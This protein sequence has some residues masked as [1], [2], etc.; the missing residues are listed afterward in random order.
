MTIETKYNIGDTVYTLYYKE[1]AKCTVKAFN[2]E[3]N[4]RKDIKLQYD[5]KAISRDVMLSGYE[6]EFI[7]PSKEEAAKDWLVN[8]GLDI[9]IK[10][11]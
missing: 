6:E 11:K 8:Q 9:D 4:Y 5:L 2:V 1:I 7:F 3:V 10:D